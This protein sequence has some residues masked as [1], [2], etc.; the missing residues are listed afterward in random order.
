MARGRTK[1]DRTWRYFQELGLIPKNATMKDWVLHHID[2]S[3]KHDDPERYHLW[4]PQDVWPLPFKV[5]SAYHMKKQQMDRSTGIMS[6]GSITKS[7]AWRRG[8][9]LSAEQCVVLSEIAK[10]R[11]G[12]KNSFYGR[13]HSEETKSRLR[14]LCPRRGEECWKFRRDLRAVSDEIVSAYNNGSSSRQLAKLYNTSKGTILKI[15]VDTGTSVR[16]PKGKKTT[17]C[18]TNR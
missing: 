11:V 7:A 17:Q 1:H 6:Q 8:R 3:M 9:K 12:S 2:E 5:H 18:L 4:R 15:L 16:P 14:A 13:H 10:T